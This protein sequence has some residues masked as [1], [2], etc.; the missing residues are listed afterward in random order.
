MELDK[1]FFE[2]YSCQCEQILKFVLSLESQKNY[3]YQLNNGKNK[4]KK[5]FIRTKLRSKQGKCRLCI[6]QTLFFHDVQRQ[7]EFLLK[8]V[9]ICD[10]E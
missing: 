4:D 5:L 7:G 9:I 10:L 3:I 1:P 6:S 8:K 2:K